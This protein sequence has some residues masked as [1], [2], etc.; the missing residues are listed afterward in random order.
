MK[1]KNILVYGLGK[2]GFAV[3]E[4]YKNK[5]I[6]PLIFD[7]VKK[8]DDL[9]DFDLKKL[10][11]AV[12]S[13]G[14][15][16][17]KDLYKKLE[18]N[19]VKIISELELG[20]QNI[21]GEV[22]AVTGTNGKTTTCSLIGHILKSANSNTFIAGNIG[23]PLISLHKK[24]N[25]KSKI[26][27]EVSSFQLM[28]IRKFRPKI[29]AILNLTPDHLTRHKTFENY[30]EAKCRIFENQKRNDFCVLNYDD[31]LTRELY[32][33]TKAKAFYFSMQDQTKNKDF[34]G[35]F[36]FNN[37]FYYKTDKKIELIMNNEKI[38]LIGNKN[39][40]NI[41]CA[42][43]VLLLC[44]VDAKIINFAVNEFL[45]LENR[46]EKVLTKNKI[47]YINDSKATNIGSTIAD[48]N[49]FNEKVVL[50][51]GG[52]DKGENFRILFKALTP[53]IYKCVLYGAT[54]ENMQKCADEVN[55]K[56]YVICED[57]DKAVIEGNKLSKELAKG[58]VQNVLLLAPACA[59]F[60]QFKNYEERGKYFKKLILNLNKK[61]NYEK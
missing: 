32:K 11:L 4:F 50:L 15:D 27:C 43:L 10:K 7:D 9:K 23:I 24:T 29:S 25:K 48:I 47:T 46:L 19:R 55:Y 36:Y 59:S 16:E 21:K 8:I 18:E 60:D 22:I 52:S 14:V 54:R 17:D 35:T 28:K 1:I 41:L 30:I 44:N 5:G 49:A 57:F 45:P 2:S 13:P 61:K 56:D 40:E 31:S 26:V 33:K 3:Q 6:T 53:N 39:K 38:K 37:K 34:V 51:L 58:G 42:I 20:F 12:V